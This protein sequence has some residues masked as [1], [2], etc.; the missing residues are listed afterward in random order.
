M[1]EIEIMSTYIKF[2]LRDSDSNYIRIGGT[3][4]VFIDQS[5]L[6]LKFK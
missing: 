2:H 5:Q 6:I 1:L 3:D 4:P